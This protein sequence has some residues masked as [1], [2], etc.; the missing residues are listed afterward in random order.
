MRSTNWASSACFTFPLSSVFRGVK[1][2]GSG[3]G[4]GVTSAVGDWA[5]RRVPGAEGRARVYRRV[6]GIPR[7][8]G[9][10]IRSFSAAGLLDR[11]CAARKEVHG[12]RA[13]LVDGRLG[14]QHGI[15]LN[16]GR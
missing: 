3:R 11:R 4:A 16:G 12:E 6:P 13:E 2:D 7:G 8:R 9:G 5:R 1:S 15:L 10:L 14:A